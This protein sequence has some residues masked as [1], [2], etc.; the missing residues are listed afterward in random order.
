MRERVSF[1]RILDDLTGHCR[2]LVPDGSGIIKLIKDYPKLGRV[3]P[4]K[5]PLPLQTGRYRLIY[6][7]LGRADAS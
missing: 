1:G 3:I 5:D 2:V 4:L 6:L 7:I